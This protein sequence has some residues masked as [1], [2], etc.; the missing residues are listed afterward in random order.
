MLKGVLYN[1]GCR[2]YLYPSTIS[3]PPSKFEFDHELQSQPARLRIVFA[4]LLVAS[5]CD[6][7]LHVLGR[8]HVVDRDPHRRAH[9]PHVS[10]IHH[11]MMAVHVLPRVQVRRD[12]G[13]TADAALGR[14][15]SPLAVDTRNVMD[16]IAALVLTNG[17]EP[18][19][20]LLSVR[21]NLGWRP[22]DDEV[23]GYGAPVAF[24]ELGQ[25]EEE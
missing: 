25:S 19:E 6:V 1:Y 7:L 8:A 15:V 20:V 17:V 10:G 13:V 18:D 12:G 2:A 5:G 11:H 9:G 23:A 24:A 4:L 21:R 3:I 14:A 22:G 16:A